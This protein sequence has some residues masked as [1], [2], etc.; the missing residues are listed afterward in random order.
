VRGII[1]SQRQKLQVVTQ[2]SKGSNKFQG[3]GA[4][5]HRKNFEGSLKDICS[6]LETLTKSSS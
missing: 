5:T 1:L 2:K 3:R 4:G 6:A